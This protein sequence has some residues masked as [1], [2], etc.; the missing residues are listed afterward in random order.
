M[1]KFI[2]V[3]MLG[4]MTA[5]ANA[6]EAYDPEMPEVLPMRDRAKIMD[7]WL[8][9]RLDRIIPDLMQRENIDMWVLIAREY[10]EDPVVQTMLPATWLSARRRTVL[11]FNRDN[12]TGNV[13]RLSV[14]RYT[15]GS[16]EAAWDPEAQPDQWAR[17]AE[18]IIERDPSNIALN[19]SSAF[20]LADGL[21]S[22]Q[23]H[24]FGASLPQEYRER[25][26]SGE[27][28][29]VGWIETR[30]AEEM[31]VYP[32]IVRMAHAIIAEG[33]SEKVITPGVTTA[34]D[35]VWWYRDQIRARGFTTW[36]HPSISIQ[37]PDSAEQ[38]M[39]ELFGKEKTDVIRR[40][41]L[42]HVDFGISYLGLNTD[43]QHHAYVLGEGEVDAPE[44]LKEGLRQANRVQDIL[45]GQFRTGESGNT[46]LARSLAEAREEGLNPT[47]YSHPIG[48]Y[49]HAAGAPI[50]MWD[51]QDGVPG[52]GE[53]PVMPNA[54]WSIELNARYNVP[55]WNGQEVMFMLEEDAYFDGEN[56]TFIDGRQDRFHLIPR[57]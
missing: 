40:G 8:E 47:I 19:I 35:V 43:T 32:S 29:A 37:R 54:A 20:A 18:I 26:V 22:N 13:E 46:V 36:F 2:V 11:V 52:S 23:Y 24:E 7:E 10:N 42:I 33:L 55:E 27:A 44:G 1:R 56:V 45:R 25:F 39:T 4:L 51:K 34:D 21:S 6:Q 15:V 38:S 17:L 28:L 41:D 50:G 31:A 5:P 14:S 57:Q 30:I 48:F 53:Y 16:F 9:M 12:E 49:G 3:M